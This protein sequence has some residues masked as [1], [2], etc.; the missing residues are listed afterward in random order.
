MAVLSGEVKIAM[1]ITG[2]GDGV[3]K[4]KAAEKAV[5]DLEKKVGETTKS[6]KAATAATSGWARS[7][8]AIKTTAKPLDSTR[9]VFENL[10]SNLLGFPTAIAGVVTGFVAIVT[11]IG[12]AGSATER[13]RERTSEYAA[14]IEGAKKDLAELQKMNGTGPQGTGG[15]IGADAGDR[16]QEVTDKISTMSDRIREA[17]AE[18]RTLVDTFGEWATLTV[19][20]E[21]LGTEIVRLTNE[22]ADLEALRTSL[23]NE[24]ATA[25]ERQ[26]RALREIKALTK[27]AVA[28]SRVID[29][30]AFGGPTVVGGRPRGGGGA[31]SGFGDYDP[32]EG[33]SQFMRDERAQA[34]VGS[35][36][37][38]TSSSRS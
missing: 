6:T 2:T 23:V 33:R 3:A 27:T 34:P 25:L 11:A 10:R 22:T 15:P 19:G 37:P 31:G 30:D 35:A 18:Q 12:D 24:T 4:T 1:S 9:S 28:G 20:Y 36:A 21:K 26:A 14:A 7:M 17:A 32:F 38:S 5:A 13:L 29:L 8:D 16:Y